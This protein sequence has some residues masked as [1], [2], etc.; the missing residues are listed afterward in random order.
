MP[1]TVAP[2]HATPA[3]VAR[4]PR[5]H[6]LETAWDAITPGT[7]VRDETGQVVAGDADMLPWLTPSNAARVER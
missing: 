4:A 1:Y 2:L 3:Q 7:V 6:T 5:F